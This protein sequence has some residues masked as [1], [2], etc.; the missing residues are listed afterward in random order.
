[1][2]LATTTTS[3]DDGQCRKHSHTCDYSIPV[4]TIKVFMHTHTMLP[5]CFFFALTTAT[6]HPFFL[7]FVLH[8]VNVHINCISHQSILI[9]VNTNKRVLILRNSNTWRFYV[10]L[11]NR[12]KKKKNEKK[13]ALFAPSIAPL[14]SNTPFWY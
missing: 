9:S 13:K 8:P 2:T 3:D 14:P 1:M 6:H 5:F 4:C 7:F 12:V 11:G 10:C